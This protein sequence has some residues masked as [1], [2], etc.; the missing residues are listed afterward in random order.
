MRVRERVTGRQRDR[1]RV[2]NERDT[3]RE[4]DRGEKQ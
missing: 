4:R 3:H 1:E 2:E